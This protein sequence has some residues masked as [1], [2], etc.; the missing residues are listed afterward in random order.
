MKLGL[1]NSLFDWVSFATN[2]GMLFGF[3]PG[4]MLYYIGVRKSILVGGIL[5]SMC[6]F[7]TSRVV[8]GEYDLITRNGHFVCVAICGTAGQAACLIFLATTQALLHHSTAI[9]TAVINTSLLVFYLG[10]DSHAIINYKDPIDD[11]SFTSFTEMLALK[12]AIGQLLNF[13]LII[14]PLQSFE[15]LQIKEII[16]KGVFYRNLGFM[17]VLISAGYAALILIAYYFGQD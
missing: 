2:F 4:L 10:A 9:A 16:R 14:E 6:L 5:L 17:Q 12:N 8:N 1:D 13:F 15:Y 11:W 7:L 3:T